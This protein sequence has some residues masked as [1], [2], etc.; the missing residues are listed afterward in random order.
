MFASKRGASP[1]EVVFDAGTAWQG[2][3][4]EAR[5][6]KPF[7]RERRAALKESRRQSRLLRRLC[8]QY[9]KAGG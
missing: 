2:S 5:R 7:S 1:Q 8:R 3:I 6:M 4:M 9:A